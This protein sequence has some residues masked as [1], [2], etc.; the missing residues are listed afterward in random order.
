MLGIRLL[1][2]PSLS[3]VGLDNIVTIGVP[4]TAT[5]ARRQERGEIECDACALKDAES[6]RKASLFS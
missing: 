1:Q 2:T 3:C 6:G 5:Y 4:Y